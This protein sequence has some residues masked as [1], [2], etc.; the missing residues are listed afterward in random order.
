MGWQWKEEKDPQVLAA[1]TSPEE[2]RRQIQLAQDKQKAE[3]AKRP[4][5]PQREMPKL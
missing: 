4:M 1:N 2:A 5:Q 3:Q